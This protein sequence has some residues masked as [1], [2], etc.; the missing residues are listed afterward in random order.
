MLVAAA[1]C[2]GVG[3][4][5]D[6]IHAPPGEVVATSQAYPIEVRSADGYDA[7]AP[8][9]PDSEAPLEIVVASRWAVLEAR[10][11]VLNTARSLGYTWEIR[12]DGMTVMRNDT[13]WKGEVRVMDDGRVEFHRAPIVFR[14]RGE[15]HKSFAAWRPCIDLSAIETCLQVGGLAVGPRR[16]NAV[17]RTVLDAVAAPA[18][19]LSTRVSELATARRAAAVPERLDA[20]WLRGTPL[21]DGQTLPAL[22]DRRKAIFRWWDS[23][24]EDAAGLLVRHAIEAYVRQVVETEAPYP[25]AELDALDEARLS[26]EAFREAIGR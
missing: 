17:R 8:P 5:Q 10:D 16:L 4:A 14:P 21:D 19:D 26:T 18:H 3:M 20:L 24:T 7:P 9:T 1:L 23:R 25:D 15:D 13:N 11:R 2:V 22:E 6:A 12:R